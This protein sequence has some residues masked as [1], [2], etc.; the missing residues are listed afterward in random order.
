MFPYLL[1]VLFELIFAYFGRKHKIA[2]IFAFLIVGLFVGLRYNVGTDYESYSNYFYFDDSFL[3][4]GFNLLVSSLQ[5]FRYGETYMFLTMSLF[6]Y[7]A[8][9]LFIEN[10]KYSKCYFPLILM[11]TLLTV[12]TTCN[13]IRQS[14]AVALFLLSTRF[15]QN[16]DFFSFLGF[17]TL[18]FLFHK[19][20][21]LVLPF[22]FFKEKY[23]DKKVYIAIYLISFIFV[24][25]NLQ[26]LM[27]PF[28]FVIAKNERYINLVEG[29][30]SNG[31]LSLGI[32]MQIF[33]YIILLLFLLK[34]EMHKKQ[35]LFFNLF[36]ISCVL[37]NMRVGAPLMNRVM[38]YFS[39]FSFV[40]LPLTLI[41][42]KSSRTKSL[43][44]IY[45]VFW[46]SSSAINYIAF[47]E[48]GSMNP[49]HDALGIF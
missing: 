23:F 25:F 49:Y 7:G 22:Y 40:L 24:F 34:N 44:K 15:I 1:L 38:M 46:Y 4:P 12:S 3:E 48:I 31:Y 45:F 5:R 13:G 39:W 27:N 37:M 41:E 47:D 26:T 17:I 43:I 6:T 10:N 20:V 36:F 16:R 42:E 33:N 29:S 11:F 21:L 30:S 19:S 28:M 9:Y 32:L 2:R 35:P 14:L 18:A 8:I